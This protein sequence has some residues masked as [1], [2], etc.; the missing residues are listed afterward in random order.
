MPMARLHEPR[1]STDVY[2]PEELEDLFPVADKEAQLD[3]R[4]RL[5]SERAWQPLLAEAVVEAG[6]GGGGGLPAH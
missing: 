4:F 5:D 2:T 1:R 6:G 3:P